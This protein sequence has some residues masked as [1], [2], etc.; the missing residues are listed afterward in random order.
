M[1]TNKSLAKIPFAKCGEKKHLKSALF[2]LRL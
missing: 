1:V 2:P